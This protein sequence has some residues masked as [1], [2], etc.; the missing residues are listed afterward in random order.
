MK[1]TVDFSEYFWALREKALASKRH[2]RRYEKLVTQ[3][4]AFLPLNVEFAGAPCF[5]HGLNGICISSSA[6][7]GKGCTIFHQVTIGSNTLLDS[8]GQGSP[9]IGDNVFIGCGAKIIGGVRVGNNVRIG[10][11][12]VVVEDVPDNCTVVLG[13]P[14]VIPKS[15]HRDN[16][17]VTMGEYRQK[18]E[19]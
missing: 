7:I 12:C 10:A 2:R 1:K 15:A 19:Q 16:R 8:D 18:A 17:F 14:R 6:K 11:N 3:S 4:N 13:K 9:I 5:P